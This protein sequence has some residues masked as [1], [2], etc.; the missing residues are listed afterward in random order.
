MWRAPA[1]RGWGLAPDAP[2]AGALQETAAALGAYGT[3][4]EAVPGD[5]THARHR[6]EPVAAAWKPRGVD[7]LVDDAGV[8][9]VEPLVP[10]E[11]HPLD[12]FGRRW[13]RT[14]SL[15]PRW[16]RRRCRSCARRRPVPCSHGRR[17]S[18]HTFVE[19]PRLLRAGYL[20]LP[21]GLL[22]ARVG[23][24]AGAEVGSQRRRGG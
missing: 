21:S 11:S 16:Y 12:G 2:G 9:G 18:H 13:R 7:L 4:V 10:L 3:R 20:P 8:L 19:L 22:P 1:A 15:R 6:S 17:V 23:G 24:P 14:W 5:V